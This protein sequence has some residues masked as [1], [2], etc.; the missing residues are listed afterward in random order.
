MRLEENKIKQAILH[1]ESE[2]RYTAVKY[3]SDSYSEDRTVIPLVIQ[4]VGK[5]G[6]Q[7]SYSL[8][9][10][11]STLPH[12]EE[13]MAWV[14]N[15]L[16]RNIDKKEENQVNYLFNLGRMLCNAEPGLLLQHESEIIESPGLLHDFKNAILERL[17]MLS[18]DGDTCWNA[19]ED[20]CEAGKDKQF[21]SDVNLDY[22]SRIV[23]ALARD[24]EKY[25]DQI[26]SLLSCEVKDFENNPMS[27]MEPLLVE[28]VGE[29][30]L[31]QA[32]PLLI[33]KLKLDTDFLAE[34]CMRALTKIGTDSVVLAIYETFPNSDDHFRLYASG[35]LEN[36]HS[37]F[38]V[39]NSLKLLSRE[40]DRTIK[41]NLALA[42]LTNFSFEGIS[43]VRKLVKNQDYD[44]TLT[45]LREDLI[46]TCTIME[47]RFPEFDQ[48]KVQI[49]RKRKERERIQKRRMQMEP[50][51]ALKE[52]FIDLQ[53]DSSEDNQK[54][55]NEGDQFSNAD[56]KTIMKIGRN[57]PCP[58]GSGK[59][60]KKCC[61]G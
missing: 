53:S 32:I 4:A 61:L 57:H 60:F 37:D 26:Q 36:I 34:Q 15:E 48:W 41:T 29:M 45:Y 11:G 2:V 14:L 28:L 12:T 54:L 47:E 31:E 1:P 38:S 58:C 5:Y 46:K 56:F 51:E 20:F 52:A 44:S 23:E 18:W 3:F 59:K 19:L 30:R 55:S 42:L 50:M 21:V 33:E 49:E 8:I 39:E 9:G 25:I 40:R 22:A 10:L 43:M 13:S 7:H 6:W 16:N 27:W 24:I 17:K 35:V